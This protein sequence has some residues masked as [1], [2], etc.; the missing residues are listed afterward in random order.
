M[1]PRSLNAALTAITN[2][3]YTKLSKR[4]FVNLGVLLS[5]LSKDIL[6]MAAIEGLCIIEKQEKKGRH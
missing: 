3:L 2:Y 6:D 5:L 1:D 4:D